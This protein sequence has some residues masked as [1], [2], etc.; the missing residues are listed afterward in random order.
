MFYCVVSL[1]PRFDEKMQFS[2]YKR[3]Y[4]FPTFGGRNNPSDASHVVYIKVYDALYWPGVTAGVRAKSKD[5]A[6]LTQSVVALPNS[7]DGYTPA[8]ISCQ[9][10]RPTIRNASALSP[11]EVTWLQRRRPM[12]FEAMMDLFGH[13]NIDD[14]DV[15]WFTNRA[16]DELPNTGIAFSGAFDARS[17]NSSFRGPLQGLLQAS[18]YV[19]GLSGGSWL[20]GSIYVNNFTTVSRLMSD[21]IGIV[22]NLS[23]SILVGPEEVDNYYRQLMDDV[24][25]KADEGFQVSIT[26]YWGRALS[27]QLINASNGVPG[28]TWS[29]INSM[30]SFIDGDQPMPIIVA[31]ERAPGERSVTLNASIFEINPWELGT[32]DPTTYSFAPLEYLGSNFTA[33]QLVDSQ[34]T[35][36]YDN[37]GFLMG[38]SSSLFNQALLQVNNTEM[39]DIIQNTVTSLLETLDEAQSDIAVFRPNPFFNYNKAQTETEIADRTLLS[40]SADTGSG[41]P[42][43]TSL[44]ATYQRSL[45]STFL[46]NGGFPH[47]PDQNTF[48]NLGLNRRPTFFGCNSANSTGNRTSPLIVYIPNA[49]Y[50]YYSNVST[51]DL[52]YD[53]DE[54]DAIIM[55]GYNV[56]SMGNSSLDSEW[57]VCLGCAVLSRSLDRTQSA[58]PAQ[59]QVCLERYCWNGTANSTIPL[60]YEPFLLLPTS[61]DPMA[62]GPRTRST[63]FTR[64]VQIIASSGTT[65]SMGSVG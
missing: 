56:A 63:I 24:G 16:E 32:W 18:T 8:E 43:G 30:Q 15:E 44:V 22:W 27:Y 48:V 49:P 13:L 55:N 60:T 42:N 12:C 31:L 46:P 36:G 61:G 41:W 65:R 45:G 28:Y 4:L 34:C 10:T 9:A 2:S 14:F 39:R 64:A 7:P 11:H 53:T 50:T 6:I 21:E 19:S 38:T 59:C 35:I 62:E 37:A 3:F 25:G 47:I 40:Y 51:F 57:P 5:D 23:N 54:R 29:S 58:T 20:V 17:D 1:Q 52:A 26:D 33:G